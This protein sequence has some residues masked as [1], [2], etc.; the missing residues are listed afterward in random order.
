MADK[1]G[2]PVKVLA[3]KV[4]DL[5]SLDKISKQGAE[6]HIVGTLIEEWGKHNLEMPSRKSP[7]P[8]RM[9]WASAF[10]LIALAIGVYVYTH[11]GIQ[12]FSFPISGSIVTVQM[13]ASVEQGE[14][15]NV[16]VFVQNTSDHAA[17]K[18]HVFLS[19]SAINYQL[20]GTNQ[21]TFD[22]L[23]KGEK[24]S[25]QLAYTVDGAESFSSGTLTSRVL[26]TQDQTTRT[27]SQSF[28]TARRILP[29][30][31]IW[32]PVSSLLAALVVFINGKDLWKLLAGLI[33][34][35]QSGPQ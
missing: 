35:V 22:E 17:A 18:V 6:Y 2:Y 29:L 1:L 27:V 28:T 30:R 32:L 16:V 15:G 7:W 26:I 11:P 12:T 25:G 13:P 23:V 14:M 4:S 21:V 24:R 9:R 5:V 33:A 10:L 20:D 8:Q 31:Q 3:E 34:F 19:S